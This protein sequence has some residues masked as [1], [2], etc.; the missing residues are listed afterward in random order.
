MLETGDDVAVG[1]VGPRSSQA[2]ASTKKSPT[3]IGDLRLIILM[4]LLE[5]SVKTTALVAKGIV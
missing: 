1:V 5:F 2:A 4:F 3:L